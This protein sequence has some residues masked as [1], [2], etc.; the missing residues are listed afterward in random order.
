MD[1]RVARPHDHRIVVVEQEEA[2]EPI[3]P[4]LYREEETEQDGAVGDDPGRRRPML[5]ERDVAVRPIYCAGD[6]GAQY[7]R[8]QHP[9]LERDIGR[10]R[11]EIETDVLPIEGIALS[12]RRLAD[13]A[14][15][16]VPVASL[17]EGDQGREDEQ[18]SRDE[19]PRGSLGQGR[20]S[21][22]RAKSAVN[23]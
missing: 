2:V 5:V 20:E 14:E 16:H 8:Q 22:A 10:K 1:V 13:K 7:E 4:S 15:D 21:A 11:E 18:S 17:A 12:V 3:G 19:T 23:V 6:K 9:V